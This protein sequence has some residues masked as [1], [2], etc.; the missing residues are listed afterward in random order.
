MALHSQHSFN[1][2]SLCS[3]YGGLELGL[4]IAEPNYRTV[5]FVER[6]AHAAATLVARMEDQALDHA[7]VWDDVKSFKGRPWR[8]RIQILSAGYPCQPFSYGGKQKGAADPRHLWPDVARIIKEAQP[9][10]VFLE[11][12]KGHIDLGFSDVGRELQGMGYGVKAGLFSAFEVGA[13][14]YRERLFILAHAN[15][16]DGGKPGRFGVHKKG[17]AAAGRRSAE[18]QP[19][20]SKRERSGVDPA[21]ADATSCGVSTKA[22]DADPLPLFA[23]GPGDLTAWHRAL[24]FAPDLQPCFLGLADGMADRVDRQRGAGN[25]VCPLAAAL[26]YRTLRDEFG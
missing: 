18:R 9:E 7:P 12:V 19:A 4:H 20:V 1:G 14:H 3:G 24:S 6:E 13:S 2:I 8:G 16:L 21:M 5:C 25:G 26:A 10:W 23:P 15:R 17:A 11:N 22:A